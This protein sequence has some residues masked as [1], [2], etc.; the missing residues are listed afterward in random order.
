[1]RRREVKKEGGVG[2]EKGGQR[3]EGKGEDAFI[4]V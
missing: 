1:M 4:F 3:R 2:K